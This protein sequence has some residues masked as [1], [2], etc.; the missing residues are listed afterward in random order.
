MDRTAGSRLGNAA[1]FAGLGIA[2]I[3][4]P[5]ACDAPGGASLPEES[6]VLALDPVGGLI[7]QELE[8]FSSDLGT[9]DASLEAWQLALEVG[10]G[11]TEQQAAQADFLVAMATWQ[12]LEM[13]QI[14]P[15][16]SSLTAVGGED[17]RDEVYSWPDAVSGCRVDTE[18]VEAVW[19]EAD[20]FTAN[21]VN[22]YGLDALEH[23]LFAPLSTECPS[24]V[25]IDAQW[26]ALGDAGVRANRADYARALVAHSDGIATELATRWQAELTTAL[27]EGASPW[28]SRSEALNEVYNALFYLDLATKDRK[29]AEPMGLR[30]CTLDCTL[31]VESGLSDHSVSWIAENLVATQ[32]VVRGGESDGFDALLTELGHGDVAVALDTAITDAIAVAE[33]MED[34][35]LDELITANPT[36]ATELY[37]AVQ[38]VTD[39]LSGDFATV[40]LLEIPSEAAGDND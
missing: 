15:A 6:I 26:T 38:L 30:D 7:Q 22:S 29:L 2:A 23:L 16:A 35:P 40:L 21:L 8:Q 18:T 13:L 5:A 4:Q 1:L 37:E 14:G 20:F 32:A 28:A 31:L 27:I 19:D 39:L 11:V 24:Q 36:A 17:L 3:L 12:R 25:G 34:Q 33:S 9:L 10:D